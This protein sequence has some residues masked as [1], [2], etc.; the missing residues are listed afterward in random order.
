MSIDTPVVLF[1]HSR[2]EHLPVLLRAICAARPPMVFVVAD[3]PR[4][5]PRDQERCRLVR[6]MI[7]AT[8]WPCPVRRLYA[9]QNLGCWSRLVSG[10]E[11]VFAETEQAIFLEDDIV[12]SASFFRF[13]DALLSLYRN[14]ADVMMVSGLNPLDQWA[15]HGRGHF[16]SVQGNAQA[17]ASWR[18]AWAGFAAARGAWSDAQVRERIRAFLDDDEQFAARDRVYRLPAH[19]PRNSWDYQWALARQMRRGLTAV[20]SGNLVLHA[21][22]GPSATHVK[23]ASMVDA[24]A[25]LHDADFPQRGPDEVKPD[26]AYDRFLFEV[27]NNRLSDESALRLARMLAERG[28]RLLALAVLRHRFE[29]RWQDVATRAGLAPMSLEQSG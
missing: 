17:W 27:T 13:C 19:S 4:A 22:Q 15:D 8:P 2:T 20:P 3:G 21:G 23:Q 24:L 18:R 5:D 9:G 25:R 7:D 14:L 26:R 29:G 10:I 6:Q 28:R 12:P 16:F 1:V 11:Q